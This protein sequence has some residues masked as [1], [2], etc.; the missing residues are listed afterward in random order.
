MHNKFISRERLLPPGDLS[1]PGRFPPDKQNP[2][3]VHLDSLGVYLMSQGN[4]PCDISRLHTI[5]QL[6][7]IIMEIGC[8]NGSIAREIARKNTKIGV[9]ATDQ[10][11]WTGPNRY[12]SSYQKTAFAW[13][14]RKLDS[15][16]DAPD[17]LVLLRAD[18]GM[19]AHLPENRLDTIFLINPEPKVGLAFME[20][21]RDQAVYRKIKPGETQIVI[22]PFSRE[23]GVT[24]CGGYEFDHDKD[25]SRGLGFMMASAFDFRK[26]SPVQWQVDLVKSSLYTGSSTQKDVYVF[27]SR[28]PVEGPLKKA[29]GVFPHL[30]TFFRKVEHLFKHRG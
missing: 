30:K 1:V 13:K 11:D 23:M 16:K 27:G 14:E 6:D 26:G 7:E 15:Q 5:L 9:I 19:L 8:G 10:Y 22:L 25:W 20:S 18:I 24:C 17:N 4:L 12:G 3:P 2:F 28:P 29:T 21:L